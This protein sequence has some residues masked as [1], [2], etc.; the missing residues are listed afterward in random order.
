MPSIS[1]PWTLYVHLQETSSVYQYAVA[2]PEIFLWG[3]HR[4]GKM[5]FWGGKI[6]K[7]AENSLFW[8]FFLLTGGANAPIPPLM[9]PLPIWNDVLL[10]SE[11]QTSK[12]I[13]EMAWCNSTCHLTKLYPT[14]RM[15]VTSYCSS[16]SAP[17]FQ[18]CLF[19]VECVFSCELTTGRAFQS[20]LT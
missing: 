15:D 6:Q 1:F 20:C 14:L 11:C 13:F 7:F 5:R 12:H 3:G 2:A 9:P 16:K 19:V 8:P 10:C 18:P 4:G 17:A